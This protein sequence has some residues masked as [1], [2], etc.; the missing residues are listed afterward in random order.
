MTVDLPQGLGDFSAD[1]SSTPFRGCSNSMHSAMRHALQARPTR[2]RGVPT[3][4]AR[5]PRAR[6][7]GAPAWHSLL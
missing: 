2:L 1:F 6:L 3:I 5:T 4:R 7:P